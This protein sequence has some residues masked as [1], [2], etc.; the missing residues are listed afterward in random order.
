[1]I[2]GVESSCDES[3]LAL[4]DRSKGIVGE[5]ISS[6]V[7]LHAE[8]GGVVPDLASREHLNNF[9]PL[10]RE[11]SGEFDIEAVT[12]IVVTAGPGLAGCLA[13]GLSVANAL[14]VALD[15][16]VY[17]AN[18]LRAHAYSVFISMYQENPDGFEDGLDR[19]LPHLSLVVSGGNTLLVRIDADRSLEILGQTIDDAAGEALDKGAKLL[20]LGYPG[21]PKLETI[22]NDGRADAFDFPRALIG[23]PNLDFSFS[24]LKTSLRYLLEKQSQ[25]DLDRIF[26]DLCASYQEAV[27]DVLIRK[28]ERALKQGSFRSIG[29]SGGVSNNQ[30]LRDRFTELGNR[31]RLSSLLAQRRHTGDNAGMIAFSH[32]F[33]GA[34]RTASKIDIKPSA[35]IETVLG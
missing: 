1:M 13:M 10:L 31:F 25:A 15:A 7:S 4:L 27:V 18:H 19:L 32:V 16:P 35:T 12:E 3:A 14:S 20:G 8:Y 17:A 11:L 21:G 2:L 9:G 22:A 24:G 6:Q 34:G 30:S 29:L 26:P 23:K 28:S 5:W 33:D